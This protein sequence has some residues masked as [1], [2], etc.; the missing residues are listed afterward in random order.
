LGGVEVGNLFEEQKVFE[1][2]V[3]GAPQ[4]RHSLTSIQELPI[5]APSGGQVRLGDVAAVRLAP[6]PAVINHDA[7]SRYVDVTADVSGRNYGEVADEVEAGLRGIAFP[8]E[9]HAEVLGDFAERQSDERRWLGFAVTAVLGIFLLLQATFGS[10]RLAGVA[11]VV[12]LASLVGGVPGALADGRV[13]SLGAL[14]GFLAI[15]GLAARSTVSLLSHYQ[16]LEREEGGAIGAPLAERG[17]R[18]RAVPILTTALATALA[19][20][21]LAVTGSGFGQETVR[22]MVFVLFGGLIT[23]TLLV[24]FVV[25]PLYLRFAPRPQPETA[26]ARVAMSPATGSAAD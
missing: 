6:N 23:S 20:V 3:W 18:D 9:F 19:L 1:V 11:F 12:L 22:P 17:A 5:D 25:P 21:P 16:R 8:L 7:V 2:V 15:L 4:T 10:W 14:V 24:L 13:V 26:P